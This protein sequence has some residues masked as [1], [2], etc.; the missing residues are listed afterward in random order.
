MS[1][2]VDVT[3]AAMA[4][5]LLLLLALIFVWADN[6]RRLR[7]KHALGLLLFGLMLTG[8]NAL[9]LYFFLVHDQLGAWFGGLP[10]VASGAMMVLR[11]AE[12]AA[13]LFLVWVTWD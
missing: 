2:W 10:D 3:R 9:G 7:S 11:L 8:E 13:L 6:Y 5:N 4:V 1:L 12:T